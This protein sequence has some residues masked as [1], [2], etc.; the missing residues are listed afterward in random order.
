LPRAAPHPSAIRVS[1]APSSARPQP[2][3][4]A[5]QSRRSSSLL[6]PEGRRIT[7]KLGACLIVGV[8]RPRAHWLIR[9]RQTPVAELVGVRR[10]EDGGVGPRKL[11][12]QHFP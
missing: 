10:A 3:S 12:R 5:R 1:F 8:A 6:C 9:R 4:R 7:Q 2:P 11:E